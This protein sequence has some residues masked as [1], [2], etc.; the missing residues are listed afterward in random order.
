MPPLGANEAMP[1]HEA[2]STAASGNA[3]TSAS[4]RTALKTG[5]VSKEKVALYMPSADAARARAAFT[6]TRAQEGVLS[7]SDFLHA[8]VMARVQ[9]L[10]E[11]YNA[12][13]PWP[14][15]ATGTL[16]RGR[17]PAL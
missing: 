9:D 1:L 2:K 14:P 16:P 13:K 10:E 6:W 15:V 3:E 11:T 4:D 17:P 12:G 5:A 8:A 7:W